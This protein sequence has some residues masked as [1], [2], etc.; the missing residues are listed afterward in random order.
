MNEYD[1]A[2]MADVL[3]RRQGYEAHRRPGAG[4]PDPVQHLLGAREGAGEGVF[5]PRPRQAPEGQG[6]ADRRRR[7]RGQPG[8]RNHRPRAYVDVVFG[9]RRC[10]ACPTCWRAP[11]AERRRWTSASRDRSS[12][13]C[14]RRVDGASAFVSIMEGCSNAT[15]ATAWCPTPRRGVQPPAR[16]RAD[17]DRRPGRPGRQGRSPCWARTSTP[18]AGRWATTARS[19]T[20]PC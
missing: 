8:G 15:A 14:R 20:L 12:T 6:H 19:P 16:R 9:P 1:S 5:R 13:T 3:A 11:E 18:T 10:T 17:R 4:R 2:K 7:L